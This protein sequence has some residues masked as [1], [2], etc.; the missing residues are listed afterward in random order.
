M[1]MKPTAKMP[2]Q[3]GN[4]QYHI[5]CRKG[6]LAPYLLMPGDPGRVSKI[7]KLWDNKKEVAFH[8]EYHSIT[9]RFKDVKISCLSTGIGAPS[10][11]IAI[12]ESARIGVHTFIR[13]GSTGAL[14]TG[15]KPGDLIINTAGFKL[16]GTSKNYVRNEYPS[17]A[18][19]E[20]VLALI[21]ACEKLNIK[22]H[23]GI[24][25]STDSFYI[26]EGRPGFKG[27]TQS[28]LKNIIPDLQ[29][30]KVVN[31]EM[32]SSALFTIASLY[33]L[34]AGAICAVFSNL[35]TDEFAIKGEKEVGLA[36]SEAVV[37]LSQWDNLKKKNRKKYFYPSLLKR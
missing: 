3:K 6:D 16:E 21:E 33:N 15:I 24:T 12:E 10:T 29:K 4:R 1:T 23:L 30:A 8:R 34:R 19:Y 36:A 17:F 20:V 13:V 37:I 18:H 35:I 31:F 32:E 5:A 14:Q 26:G 25:A 2:S 22:Y 9:G 7:A 11:A 28:Y 27:Y